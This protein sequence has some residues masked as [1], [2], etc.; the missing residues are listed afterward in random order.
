MTTLYHYCSASTF[1]S[2]IADRSI[3]LS[4][5]SLSNDTMEGK[6]VAAIFRSLFKKAGLDET[7]ASI[8]MDSVMRLE[9][10]IDGLGFCLS[11]SGDLLSQWRGYAQDGQGF[12]IGFSKQYLD[13]LPKQKEDGEYGF[14]LQQVIYD[15]YQQE[16]ALKPIFAQIMEDI[17]A[18]KLDMPFPP[19]LL[20]GYGN[21]EAEAEYE[22]KKERYLEAIKQMT[23]NVFQAMFHLYTLK[24]EA[25]RE[26]QEWRL[27]SYLLK[28]EGDKCK[29]RI[30]NDR[31][32]PYRSFKLKEIDTPTIIEVILGPKNTTPEFV[33][34]KF[35]QQSGFVG[36]SVRRS[37]ATYR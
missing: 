13:T 22:K 23:I 14:S 7:K 12:S 37:S 28:G 33:V 11:E 3:W 19:G 30:S 35:L 10:V 18:G 5:L 8:V 24:N 26:E 1:A 16:G 9:E 34:S 15:P 25:F 4:S 32:I 17:E 27:I 6:L 2:I 29:F 31:L 21:P 20:T 36:T